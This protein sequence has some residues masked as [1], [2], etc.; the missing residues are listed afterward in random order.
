MDQEEREGNKGEEEGFGN[1]AEMGLVRQNGVCDQQVR[2]G[3]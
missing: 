1:E 2:L 3:G